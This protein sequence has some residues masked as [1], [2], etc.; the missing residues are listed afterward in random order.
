V[1]T[2]NALIN[3]LFSKGIILS[4]FNKAIKAKIEKAVSANGNVQDAK[5]PEQQ[6]YELTVNTL[7]GKDQFYATST[8]L[9]DRFSSVISAL[10]AKGN[11]D[12]VAN[13]FLYARTE[14]NIRNM[15]IFGLVKFANALRGAGVNFPKLRQLVNDVIRRADQITDVLALSLTEFG[16]K[17]ALPQA[18]KRGL[19]DAFNKFDEYQ[20]A[21][22]NRSGSV[23]LKDALRIV[24]A[25]PKSDEKSQLLAKIMTDTLSTPDTWEVALSANGQKAEGERTE[26]SVLWE[27]LIQSKKLGYQAA[28]KNLRNMLDAG[29]SPDAQRKLSEFLIS[30]A[31]TSKSLPFEFW[32]ALKQVQGRS[33]IIDNAIQGA[34]NASV[35][36]VPRL[37]ER[38]WVIVDTSGSMNGLAAESANF[39]ASVIAKAHEGCENFALTMFASDAK[40]V[41]LDLTSS[42]SA[43]YQY[44]SRMGGGGSTNFEAALAQEA[45]LGFK[46]DVV[47]VL[48]DNEINAFGHV[49]G[50]YGSGSYGVSSSE[51]AVK[52]AAPGAIKFV[53]NAATSESTPMPKRLGWHQLAGLSTKLFDYCEA[54][55]K[56]SSIVKELSVPYPYKE[57]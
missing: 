14:M 40:Q 22:Y 1:A 33:N 56:G 16:G 11:L 42:I 6:F 28:L 13:M 37:G 21:K 4:Q 57:A 20:F 32:T 41:K 17:K 9:A 50:Y 7:Y 24:H 43:N 48:T 18:V 36:N 54:L 29:I 3:T 10:V 47:I 44:L 19:S 45:H 39:F 15:P 49:H 27:E 46:P 34:M 30:K 5:S 31:A 51:Q 2:K 23:T 26:K 53:I 8:E 38:V 35:A 52:L 12:Y 55:K 25:V